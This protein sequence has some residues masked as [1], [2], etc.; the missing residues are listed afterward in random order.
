MAKNEEKELLNKA[1]RGNVDAMFELGNLYS[2]QGTEK[3]AQK[4]WKKAKRKGHKLGGNGWSGILLPK[5]PMDSCTS[6]LIWIALVVGVL[7]AIGLVFGW[8]IVLYILTAVIVL[9]VVY[10]GDK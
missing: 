5:K 6:C 7:V 1:K 3:E 9:L 4:W 10:E 2:F 8:N